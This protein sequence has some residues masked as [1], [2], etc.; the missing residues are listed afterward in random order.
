MPKKMNAEVYEARRVMSG[1]G[2]EVWVDDDYY[3]EVTGFKASI[4]IDYSEVKRVRNL[5]NGKKISGISGE[6]EITGNHVRSF[7]VNKLLDDMMN[8]IIPTVNIIGKLDDP[9]AFG[10]ERCIF[11]NCTFEELTLMDW[12][13][14]E[15]T[16]ES[17]SF[18]FTD[19]DFDERVTETF[20]APSDD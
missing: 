15:N 5:A 14:G 17:I 2:G 16:E 6:G 8:G 7:W 4:K 1:T 13:N 18:A 12:K 20:S 9:D 10:A 19:V 3:G 11:K